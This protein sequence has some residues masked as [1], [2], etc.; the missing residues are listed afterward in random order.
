MTPKTHPTPQQA[1]KFPLHMD[2]EF[3]SIVRQTK[4]EYLTLISA[5]TLSPVPEADDYDSSELSLSDVMIRSS[6]TTM[7]NSNWRNQ[8]QPLIKSERK[9]DLATQ[10]PQQANSDIRSH[11]CSPSESSRQQKL[12][13]H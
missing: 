8:K 3:Y 11:S 2:S 6:A 7:N 13:K 10:N 1:F 12:F 9:H 5:A 4:H